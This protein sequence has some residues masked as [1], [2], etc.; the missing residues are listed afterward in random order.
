MTLALR[1]ATLAQKPLLAGLF[2]TYREEL[3]RIGA[4]DPG[5][6]PFFDHYWTETGRWPYLVWHEGESAGLALVYAGSI[7]GQRA[8]HSLAEFYIA[9]SHRREGIGAAAAGLIFA[10]HPGQWELAIYKGNAPALAFWPQAMARAG[11]RAPE[12]LDRGEDWV[13]RFAV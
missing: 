6:Y 5:V 4:T 1:L 13:C 11:G 7:S 10:A 8:D 3:V 9:P 12:R 2:E